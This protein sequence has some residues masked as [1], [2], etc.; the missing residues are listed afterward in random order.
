M[1]KFSQFVIEATLKTGM[2]FKTTDKTRRSSQQD[3]SSK[4]G[5]W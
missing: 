2:V 4:E 5:L 1:K 3:A